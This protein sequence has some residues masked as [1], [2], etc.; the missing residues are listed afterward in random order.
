MT[1]VQLLSEKSARVDADWM[2]LDQDR[3]PKRCFGR[4]YSLILKGDDWKISGSS[5]RKCRAS[6]EP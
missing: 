4:S 1:D 3:N 6:S 5:L 2:G